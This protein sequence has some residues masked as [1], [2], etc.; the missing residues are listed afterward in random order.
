MID[1]NAHRQ[2]VQSYLLRLT[3]DAANDEWQLLLKPIDGDEY[4]LFAD[5]AT[6]VE[7]LVAMVQQHPTTPTQPDQTER[8]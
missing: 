8:K 6:F 4:F 7:T 2:Q 1:E 3:R 5:V